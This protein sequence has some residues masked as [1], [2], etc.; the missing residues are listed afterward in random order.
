MKAGTQLVFQHCFQTLAQV[1]FQLTI[2]KIN[3]LNGSYNG[4]MWSN[5]Q[6]TLINEKSKVQNDM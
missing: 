4:V 6:N 2:S 1:S 5:L 3:E